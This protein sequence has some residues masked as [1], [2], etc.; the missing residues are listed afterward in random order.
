M[1]ENK[2]TIS[3]KDI[4]KASSDIEISKLTGVKGWFEKRKIMKREAKEAA[5]SGKQ[6]DATLKRLEAEGMKEESRDWDTR[7]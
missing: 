1:E 4:A 5:E 6:I 7:I 2:Y 3:S